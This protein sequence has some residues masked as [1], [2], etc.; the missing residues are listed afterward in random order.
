M[1]TYIHFQC[2]PL[3]SRYDIRALALSIDMLT[4][5]APAGTINGDD[6][7]FASVPLFKFN[8]KVG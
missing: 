1:I 8:R 5:D 3:F 6:N 2:S 7:L 4:L